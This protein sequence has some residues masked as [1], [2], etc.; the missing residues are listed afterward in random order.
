M[1]DPHHID[2]IEENI[3]TH[4]VKVAIGIAI[5]AFALIA[6]IILLVQFA[7]GAYASRSLKDDPAMSPE[8]VAKRLA[9]V[10][11]L[12]ID[13]NAPAPA[14]PAAA[15]PV[16]SMVTIPP[17]AAAKAAGAA[18]SGKT[19]YD[20]VCSVCH[21]AGVAGAPKFGDKAVWG[22]RAKAGKDALHASALKGKGA[23]PPKGGNPTLADADVKA[24]VDYMLAAAK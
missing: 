6:G 12:A 10:A 2:P 15:G 21:A 22:V 18:D 23:M 3:D 7:V 11:M 14:A 19:T 9:P 8:A 4:P 5:G 17:P 16:L 1:S 20:A 13:P 24:A